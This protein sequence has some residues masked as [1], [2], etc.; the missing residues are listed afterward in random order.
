M[1]G[2]EELQSCL[3]ASIDKRYDF[4]TRQSERKADA[5]LS[6]RLCHGF[7]VGRHAFLTS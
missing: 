7:C 3:A 5:A 6:E 4:A 2:E 1:A